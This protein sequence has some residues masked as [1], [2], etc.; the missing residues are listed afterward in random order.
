MCWNYVA[1]SGNHLSACI[2]SYS[3]GASSWKRDLLSHAIIIVEGFISPTNLLASYKVTSQVT[4]QWPTSQVKS[5]VS[6]SDSSPSQVSL[7]DSSPTQV[8]LCDSS[9]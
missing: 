2:V 3:A 9:Q 7:T 4:S 1:S 8:S 5:Q 6:L